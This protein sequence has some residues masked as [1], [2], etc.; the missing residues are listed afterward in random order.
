[1]KVSI[2]T[3]LSTAT[4]ESAI[5]PTPAEI[6]NGRSRRIKASTPPVSERHAGKDNQG[7]P[8]RPE[9]PEQQGEDQQ[10]RGRNNQ[11]KALCSG[12][13]LLERAAIADPVPCRNF[14]FG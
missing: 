12:Y 11:R 4:P 13:E 5:K 8:N 10:Q 6:D 1:M 14:H 3:P 2:T 7:V 9:Q